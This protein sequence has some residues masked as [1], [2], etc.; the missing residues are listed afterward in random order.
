[1][2]S[3]YVER[4]RSEIDEQYDLYCEDRSEYLE[5]VIRQ[6]WRRFFKTVILAIGL[7]LLGNWVIIHS[8]SDW[9][10]R[11]WAAKPLWGLLMVPVGYVL[12]SVVVFRDYSTSGR[13]KG[14]WILK[15]TAFA[16]VGQGSYQILVT[17]LDWNIR[18]VVWG[19]TLALGTLSFAA[20]Y[21]VFFRKVQKAQKT[22]LPK[23]APETT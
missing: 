10:V 20:N 9:G 5:A 21:W 15:T 16:A 3:L 18:Y 7:T 1:V 11:A 6:Q 2:L 14:R 12:N 8:V 4:L 13:T 23:T 19:Q 22:P 17:W